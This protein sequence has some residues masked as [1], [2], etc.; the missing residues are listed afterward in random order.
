MQPLIPVK[1]FT[2]TFT[3]IGSGGREAE[4][5]GEEVRE[6]RKGDV[7]REGLQEV[8]GHRRLEDIGGGWYEEG[9]MVGARGK[10]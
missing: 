10:R 8:R 9:G 3:K 5:N 7:G 1:L 2:R 4:G 6:V